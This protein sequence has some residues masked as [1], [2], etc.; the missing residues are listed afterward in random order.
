MDF[1]PFRACMGV[2]YMR[3]VVQYWFYELTQL[4]Q[5]LVNVLYLFITRFS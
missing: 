3:V 4:I 2:D 1:V 5:D